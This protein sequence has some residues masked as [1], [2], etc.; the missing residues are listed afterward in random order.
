MQKFLKKIN[1]DIRGCQEEMQS[2]TNEISYITKV[3][4]NLIQRGGRKKKS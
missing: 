4:H 1:Q 3:W 2:V